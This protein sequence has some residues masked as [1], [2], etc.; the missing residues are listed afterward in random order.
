MLQQL[1]TLSLSFKDSPIMPILFLGHGS[2]LNALD[3]NIFTQNWSYI[4]SELPKPNAILCISAHW[5]TRGTLVT[6]MYNPKTIHDFYGFPQ[7]LFD[8]E[9]PAP[10]D[11]ELA[12]S[13]QETMTTHISLDHAWG[14]DHGAWSVIKHLYPL[15]DIPVLQLSLD[16]NRSLK[17]HYE[18]AKELMPL[19][20]KGVLII[21]SGNTVHNL[22]LL[23]RR[24]P[25]E[26]HDWAEEARSIINNAILS[27]QH[28]LLMDIH[29][30]GTALELAVPT[31]EHFLPLLYV[32]GLKNPEEQTI[33]FNDTNVLGSLAMTSVIVH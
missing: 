27:N 14:L 13:I 30:Q 23:D 17:E 5:E 12:K 31:N 19:R 3:D 15:A 18:L 6:A 29:Q 21:G 16:K 28:N 9:Y 1:R 22:R 10:G 26:G 4:G 11:P 32:L 24:K 8:V 2:P 25:E 7:A 33:L 20:T